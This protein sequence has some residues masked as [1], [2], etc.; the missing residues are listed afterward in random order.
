MNSVPAP[1][2]SPARRAMPQLW[3][4]EEGVS[5]YS[6]TVKHNKY[7]HSPLFQRGGVGKSEA[8]PL[9]LY[10]MGKEGDFQAFKGPENQ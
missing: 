7:P 6:G 1:E 8:R 3:E 9:P 4:G 10:K 2:D 5:K